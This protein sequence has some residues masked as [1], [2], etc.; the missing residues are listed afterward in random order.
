MG[1]QTTYFVPDTGCFTLFELVL[2]I[3]IIRKKYCYENVTICLSFGMKCDNVM[4]SSGK[5]LLKKS[6]H[7]ID[8]TA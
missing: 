1:S 4:K 2:T 7:A 5:T 3:K 8:G 6:D